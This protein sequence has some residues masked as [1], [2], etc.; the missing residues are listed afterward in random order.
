LFE[1]TFLLVLFAVPC[2]AHQCFRVQN[3]QIPNFLFSGNVHVQASF[4]A[5][6]VSIRSND[7]VGPRQL[8]LRL[9]NE[10]VMDGVE[11]QLQAVGDAQFV[12]D[13]VQVILHSLFR[14]EKFLAYLLVAESLRHQLDDLF[15]AV[16]QQR[17][18]APRTGLR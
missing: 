15:F 8:E 7:L 2:G 9:I 6:C 12:E 5:N 10:P 4:P 14:N 11:R 17:L 3:F 13:I 1:L 16:A 18:L